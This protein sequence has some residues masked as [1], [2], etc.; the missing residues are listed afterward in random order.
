MPIE[1]LDDIVEGLADAIGVYGSHTQYCAEDQ[2]CRCC[3][4][5]ELKSRIKAAVE[6]ER[7]LEAEDAR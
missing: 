5:A 1:T 6:V 3:W 7:K 4:T 2:T